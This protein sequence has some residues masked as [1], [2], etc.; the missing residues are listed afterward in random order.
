MARWEE[1]APGGR[2]SATVIRRRA[3][4]RQVQLSDGQRWHLPRGKS[5]A[6]IPAQD[7]IGDMLQEAVTKATKKWGP[8]TLSRN[9][10]EAID[11]ALKKGKYWLARLLEREA[12]G[13]FVEDEVSKQFRHLYNFSRN[14][15]VDVEVPK[16]EILSGT[17]SNL[18]HHGRRRV[19]ELFRMLTLSTDAARPLSAGSWRGRAPGATTR[20]MTSLHV[21]IVGAGP[22]GSSAATFLAQQGARVTL[23]ERNRF[24]RDKICG[25]GCTPRTLWMLERLGLGE[26]PTSTDAAPVVSVYALSPGGVVVEETIPSRL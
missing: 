14:K 22:A 12:W 9:E 18:A 25:D 17:A 23:L 3:G 24:P 19:G 26:L 4:N 21:A 16:Y 11:E 1:T 7:K 13:R 10:R 6:D 20:A 5:A 2:S 8:H 15:G